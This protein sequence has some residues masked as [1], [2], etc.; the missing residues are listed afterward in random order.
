MDYWDGLT[1]PNAD[2]V[3]GA[4]YSHD[5]N[6]WESELKRRGWRGAFVPNKPLGRK[7]NAAMVLLD[8]CDAV[9][10]VGS[11]D[12]VSGSWV[13]YAASRMAHTDMVG[14][15]SFYMY[16]P[17]TDRTLYLLAT[18]IGG[19]RIYSS[20]ILDK[21]NWQLWEPGRNRALDASAI[22]RI[23]WIHGGKQYWD[24]F[25]YVDDMRRKNAA[26]L[27]VKTDNIW[28]FDEVASGHGW[29]YIPEID[30]LGL[31]FPTVADR[32]RSLEPPVSS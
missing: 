15:R 8:D 28:S 16:D 32:L 14:L 21:L 5:G 13:R 3:F 7:H 4:S 22:N 19:G 9:M 20:R 18:P 27:A 11:D 6:D 10:V 12:F 29:N 30:I 2:L 31:Y 23:G 25:E 26:L 1:V 17:Y 24:R